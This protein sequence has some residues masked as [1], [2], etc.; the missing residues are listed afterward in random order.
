MRS[1]LTKALA[2]P[3]ACLAL[4]GTA[5]PAQADAEPTADETT[6]AVNIEDGSVTPEAAA[7]GPVMLRSAGC[8]GDGYSGSANSRCTS[9]TSGALFHSKYHPNANNGA[10]RTWYKKTGGSAIT[11]KLGYNKGGT[12]HYGAAVRQTS[13]T[14]KSKTWTTSYDGICSSTVGIM[15][16]SGQGTFQTPSAHC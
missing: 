4:W 5:G 3:A 7:D 2:V 12:T 6:V 13:G 10:I 11:V 14:T 16:V 15:S 9:L 1:T 8:P